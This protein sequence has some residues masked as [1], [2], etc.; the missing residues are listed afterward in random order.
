MSNRNAA[1]Q[2][3]AA[4][5]MQEIC[6]KAAFSGLPP[7]ICVIQQFIQFMCA[8]PHCS[9]QSGFPLCGGYQKWIDC[10]SRKYEKT[11]ADNGDLKTVLSNL[12]HFTG[13]I[14]IGVI[15]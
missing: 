15:R 4:F 11:G 1:Q 10:K 5:F 7:E 14:E 2:N 12:F 8:A 3:C 13:E 6:F 9:R